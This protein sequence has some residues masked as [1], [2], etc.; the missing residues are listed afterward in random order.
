MKF[1]IALIAALTATTA[2]ADGARIG[3]GDV[4]DAVT[5]H[6]ILQAP[7]LIE[8]TPMLAAMGPAAPVYMIAGKYAVKAVAIKAGVDPE[9]ANVTIEKFGAFGAANNIALL[10]GANPALAPVI[11]VAAALA[12]GED[13]PAHTPPTKCDRTERLVAGRVCL[14]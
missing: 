1:A 11:G 6:M 12:Y 5:T 2:T 10:A 8:G 9:F 13:L 7:D 14:D 4:A 3:A